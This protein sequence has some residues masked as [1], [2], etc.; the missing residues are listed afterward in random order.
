MQRFDS[1]EPS[2]SSEINEKIFIQKGAI[3]SE[4]EKKE[5]EEEDVEV[6]EAEVAEEKKMSERRL[7]F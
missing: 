1:F 6:E 4:E 2:I 3:K 5:E 7:F